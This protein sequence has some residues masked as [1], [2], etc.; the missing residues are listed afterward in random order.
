M[1]NVRWIVVKDDSLLFL[2][3]NETATDNHETTYEAIKDMNKTL[4]LSAWVHR[5]WHHWLT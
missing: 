3:I 1:P 5:S 4:A 2:C